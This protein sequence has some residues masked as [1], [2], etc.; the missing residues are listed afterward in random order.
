MK[1]IHLISGGDVGGA[2]THVLSLLEELSRAHT[3]LLVCFLE[4]SFA[5]EARERGIQTKVLPGNRI[6][7]VCWKLKRIIREGGFELVHCHGSRAN[8]YGF[9]LKRFLTVPVIT[10]VHSDPKMD[11]LGRPVGNLIY[12][13][14]NRLALRNMDDWVCVSETLRQQLIGGGLNPQNTFCLCNGVKFTDL[15]PAV[16]RKRYWADAGL[17]WT[18]EC[19][20]FGIAARISPVKDIGTLL[21]AFAKAVRQMPNLR[22]AIA[23][24]G[25]QRAEM[26]HLAKEICPP[27]TVRFLGWL[28][29]TDGFYSAIDVNLLTSLSEG[30]PY[31]IAEGARMRC[32]TIATAVGAVPEIILDGQTGLLIPP[33]EPDIL[34]EAMLKLSSDRQLRQRL[35]E[36]LFRKA[37]QELSVTAMV[38]RQTDIYR[39]VFRRRERDGRKRDGVVICGAYGRGNQG[40]EAI[41]ESVLQQLRA[42]D[43]DLPVHVLSRSPRLTAQQRN[44]PCVY[45]FSDWKTRRLMR[46][47]KLYISGGGSLIQDATS[48]RSLLFYLYSIR[49]AHRLGCRVMMYGCGIGPVSGRWNRR[50]AARVMNA[51]VDVIT[52]RDPDS[53]R[54]LEEMGVTRPEIHV[55]A[56]PAL[57]QAPS[58]ARTRQFQAYCRQAGLVPEERYCLFCLRPWETVQEQ[59]AAFAQAAEYAYHHFG[60]IPVFFQLE[61]DR[62]RE[63]TEQTAELVSCPKR[64]LPPVTDG[65][66]ICSLMGQMQMVVSMRLHALIFASGQGIPLVGI[67]YDP[68]VTGFL[69]YLGQPNYVAW[70]QITGTGLCRLMDRALEDGGGNRLETLRRLAEENGK[71]AKRLLKEE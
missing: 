6:G 8:L 39:T 2:K 70:D 69:E 16:D 36:A 37:E 38:Q 29:D 28:S 1:M 43:A 60:M 14:L 13:T 63:M 35:G 11:Y 40:D 50:I 18:E 25:E 15:P 3:V 67:S 52:L 59:R 26:E 56:D 24:D 7:R 17:P 41:L 57:L 48:T 64:I 9:L 20:V 12:G 71:I 4:G 49:T 51:C 44:V 10:T 45:T 32:A 46:R 55:T 27:G 53:A 66:L 62:D 34:M 33:A 30:M 21:N 31:V 54:F 65:S 47:S 61:P 5:Q 68:K 42:E 22:L 23:G 19:V 58:P